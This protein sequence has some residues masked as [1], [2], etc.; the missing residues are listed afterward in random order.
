VTAADPVAVF[1]RVLLAAGGLDRAATVLA[2]TADPVQGL[3]GV[4][5][6]AEV[7]LAPPP[8]DWHQGWYL[9]AALA[10][11]EVQGVVSR[12]RGEA[13]PRPEGVGIYPRRAERSEALPAPLPLYEHWSGGVRALSEATV[14][15]GTGLE[16]VRRGDRVLALIVER[17]GGG[18]EADRRS[19]W[20]SWARERPWSEVATQLGVPDLERLEVTGRASSGRATGLVAVGSSGVRKEWQGFDIRRTLDLPE[21]L[22]TLHVMTR[23]DGTRVV[24]FLGRGW[25]HGI[26]LC[27]NGAYGLARAGRRFEEILATYYPGTSV[28]QWAG[29]AA[30]GSDS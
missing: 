26:G 7:A 13:V 2:R 28:V 16:R 3:L 8:P 19:A 24:R 5:D 17:S 12:D 4:C 29:P 30:G 9:R 20:R 25:G 21:S 11:L 15:P 23:D 27:Q 6:L 10:V 14:L 1:A 22:F 18:G